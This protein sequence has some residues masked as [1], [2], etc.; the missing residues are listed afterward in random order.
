MQREGKS[1]LVAAILSLI[2]PGVG[3]FYLG[4]IGKG[5]MFLIL[6]IVG[7]SLTASVVGA[8]VGI[9]ML[10]IMPIWAAIDA[11]LAAKAE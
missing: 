5:L 2:I 8:I 6:Q 9:P 7:A 10:I 11:Y 4:V 3:H 1:A